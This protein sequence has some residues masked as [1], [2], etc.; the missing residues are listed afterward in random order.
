MGLVTISESYQ[1]VGIIDSAKAGL[2]AGEDLDYK[3]N[4]IPVLKDIENAIQ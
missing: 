2:D 3:K 1:I 4:N